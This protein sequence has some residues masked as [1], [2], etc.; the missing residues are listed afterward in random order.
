MLKIQKMLEQR[1]IPD[2]LIMS[3]GKRVNGTADFEKRRDEIKQLLMREE[4][5]II[6]EKP[7]EMQVELVSEDEVFCAGKAP[8]KKLKFICR[9]AEK[10]CSFP[11]YSVIPAGKTNIP[12]FIH[13]NFRD[14][15]PDRYMHSEEIIDRGYA[16]FSFCY[17]DVA[18]DSSDFKSGCAKFLCPSR[19]KKDAPGKIAM[20]AW[21]AMRVMDYVQTLP[22]IDKENI[23]VVGH[24]RLGKTA[25]VTGAYD[26][27]F[28]YMIS[29][30][31]GCSGA[32]ISRGKGGESVKLITDTFPYWFCPR[33]RDNA[34]KFELG[35][36][37]QNFL[38]TLCVPRH[39][40][41]GSAEDDLWADPTSEFLNI[42]SMSEAYEI[43]GK[44][45]LVHNDEIPKAKSFLYE[46]DCCY[47][48][49]KGL[50]YF[51]RED[52]NAYMDYIDRFVK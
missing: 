23:A 50:H 46:G 31:S 49:R 44:C 6:P 11:V 2:A 8:L 38:L 51:S 1:G 12:A 4:Y 45:G 37:D 43:F 36:F 35:C 28:K 39:I 29:N 33:Y 27:R 17:E 40:I 19:R 34:D 13:I 21:A 41:I 18:H 10:E 52:W 20:W 48:I 7:K 15:V 42:A 26:E 22:E 14:A 16:V 5:G 24:S 32:A 25:L 3:S 47:H 30:D 9:S